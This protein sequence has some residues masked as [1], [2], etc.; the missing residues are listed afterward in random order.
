MK[1]ILLITYYWENNESVGKKRWINFISELRKSNLDISV[2]TFSGRDNIKK[3]N[4][5]TLI[6]RNINSANKF[7]SNKI[8]ENYSRGV[9]DSSNNILLSLLSW[10]RVNFFFPDGRILSFKK[11]ENFAIK[12]ITENSIDT[13][14]TTSPPHSIQKLGMRIKDRSGVNWISDFRDPYLNW[15]IL[16]SMKPNFISKMIHNFYQ[17][18]FIEASDKVIVTNSELK[19]EFLKISNRDKI[20][21]IHNGSN[22]KPEKYNNKKFILSYFGLLNMF[23]NPKELI[24]TLDSMLEEDSNFRGK[25]EFHLF[26]NIQESTVNYIDKKKNLYPLTKFDVINSEKELVS[27]MSSSSILLLLLDNLPMQNTTPY[28]LFEYLVSEKL[29][30]TLGDYQNKDVDRFLKDYKRYNRMRYDDVNE[31]RSF[32]KRSFML[33][34]SKKL[35]NININ[36]SDLRYSSLISKLIKVIKD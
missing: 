6:E 2:L 28:K 8:V 34:D 25:F 32:I 19:K 36:Y 15:N 33:Y 35:K 24:D 5:Y 9:I 4:N 12:Y 22:I 11:I 27:K 14:I 3:E 29:I 17:K 31:I 21:L 10:I 26:G 20:H 7:F 16:L 23:R 13:L 30:L 18:K 1:K